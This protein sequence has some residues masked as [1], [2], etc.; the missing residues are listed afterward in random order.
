MI[1]SKSEV[2]MADR[3]SALKVEY[4]YEHS[5]TIGRGTKYPDFTLRIS[6]QAERFIRGTTVACC[7]FQV[8]I[9]AGKRSSIGIKITASCRM[10]KE[11]V[12]TVH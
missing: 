9:G 2:I 12:K 11:R 1:Q 7:M 5:L 8:T 10:K 3:L 4:M 6:N